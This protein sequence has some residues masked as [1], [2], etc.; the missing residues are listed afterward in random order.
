MVE[1]MRKMIINGRGFG[2]VKLEH[3]LIFIMGLACVLTFE[4]V[5]RHALSPVG[6]VM[7]LIVYLGVLVGI[8]PLPMPAFKSKFGQTF[9]AGLASGLVDSYIVL[10]QVKGIS[11][12]EEG[13]DDEN[14][15]S[16]QPVEGAR[17]KFLSLITIAALI[18]GLIIWFGEVYAA[19]L[20]NND[21]RTDVRSALFVVPP[22]LVF[23]TILGL[24]AQRLPLQIVTKDEPVGKR[25]KDYVRKNFRYIIG[26]SVGIIGLLLTHNPLLCLGVLLMVAVV[27]GRAEHALDIVRNHIEVSIMLVLFIALLVSHHMIDFSKAVGIATGNLAPV[28]PAMVQAVL[29]GPIYEDPSVH[30]WVRLTTLSTGAMILPTSS[31]VGVMLFKTK[32]QWLT[33]IRYSIPYAV[34]WFLLMHGWVSLTLNTPLGEWLEAWAHVASVHH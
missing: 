2:P 14:G 5:Y 28:I 26:F 19:G 33:Y 21:G 20:Y 18:G 23:L 31:L 15:G 16:F 8:A 10:E 17:A 27:I 29:W 34:L 24:H 25:T 32:E 30:F 12:T 1:T 3:A 4:E 9:F 13:A 6:Q 22:V 11:T 7:I